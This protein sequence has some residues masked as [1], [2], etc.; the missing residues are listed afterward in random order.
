M[1]IEQ[2][3]SRI[4]II[5]E[6]TKY[7]LV[8]TNKGDL[9]DEY[10]N[11]GY[12]S[13]GWDYLT[14]DELNGKNE[15]AIKTKIAKFEGFDSSKTIDKIKITS[16]YNKLI[17]FLNIKKN[18]VILI[19]SR[20]SDRIAFGKVDD[21]NIYEDDTKVEDGSYFKKRKVTWYEIKNIRDLN[22]V[23]YQIKSN[24]HS[25]SSI[26]RFAPYVDRVMEN[27]YIKDNTTHY[28]LNIQKN[29]NIN[30]EDLK[31]LMDNINILVKNIND[32]FGFNENLD[33]FYI[34]IN[35]NSKGAIE[36]I[37]AGKSLAV[38][39]YILS[40]VSCGNGDNEKNSHIKKILADN[41]TVLNQTTKTIDSLEVDING[42]TK[43]FK[44]GK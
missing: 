44:D 35:L 30:F 5:N 12:I 34:K 23:F 7:W 16:S 11:K 20:N 43:P 17:T 15:E 36:L 27:L 22:P 10:I 31:I 42:L 9:F 19:P 2:L 25:I 24:Q 6:G 13:L 41:A 1:T 14:L 39:A 28:V 21:G 4:E 38:M 29:E 26:D 18:D 3:L 33:E 8:R 32:E 37:K 40:L